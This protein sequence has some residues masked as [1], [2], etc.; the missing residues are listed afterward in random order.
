MNDKNTVCMSSAKNNIFVSTRQ[1]SYK[2][3][4]RVMFH[5][6]YNN[7]NKLWRTEHAVIAL[8]PPSPLDTL[9]RQQKLRL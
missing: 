5:T 3:I 9:D 6:Y 2:S 1:Y 8:S 4:F 7:I